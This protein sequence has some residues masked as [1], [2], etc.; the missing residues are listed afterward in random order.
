MQLSSRTSSKVSAD[1][2]APQKAGTVSQTLALLRFLSALPRPMGV[3]AIARELGLAPSSCFKILKQLCEEDFAEF[4]PETKCYSLGASAVLL[5]RGALDPGNT[6]SLIR[7]MLEDF[8]HHYGCALGFWRR[9]SSGRIMLAGFVENPGMMRIHMPIGQRLPMFI[10][11]VGRA[12]A[13]EMNLS[14]AEIER[15]FSLLRWQSP[16]SLEEYCAQVEQ[17]RITGYAVDQSNFAPGVTT[18]ATVFADAEGIVSYG[19]SAI[20][21]HGQVNDEEI[22]RNG[23]R[24][25]ELKQKFCRNWLTPSRR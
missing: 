20:R 1:A 10:G 15:E 7:P 2:A 23:T 3:N 9:I 13:A 17:C 19:I 21:L 24:L 14:R 12:F 16:I 6:F 18:V 25:V 5:A 11:A 8:A 4:N 22:H